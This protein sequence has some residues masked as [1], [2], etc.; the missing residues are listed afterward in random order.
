MNPLRT[1][2]GPHP[3]GEIPEN[4]VFNARNGNR[5]VMNLTGAQVFGAWSV[6]GS[7]AKPF[8]PILEDELTGL[9]RVTWDA[10]MFSRPG[11][12]V[13]NVWVVDNGLRLT[14]A[15]FR[16]HLYTPDVALT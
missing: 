1:Q 3:V 5:E 15:E 12:F 14:V 6:A 13:A 7:P 2:L 11:R 10:E 9:I 4:I 16:D 8:Y